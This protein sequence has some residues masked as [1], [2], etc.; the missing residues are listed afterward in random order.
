MIIQSK[1]TRTDPQ[2][3]FD[4]LMTRLHERHYRMTP[5]RVA[6]VRLLAA[7]EG[8]PG[9]AAL[10]DKLRAQFPTTSL[11]TVYKTLAL[12]DELGEVLELDF[13]E[14]TR[15]DGN[16]PYPHAHLICIRC[17]KIVDADIELDQALERE[18]AQ[19]SGFH[20]VGHRL[21]FQG[22]CPE[23]QSKELSVLQRQGGKKATQ[24]Q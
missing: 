24:A 2:A 16:R 19:A 23:C 20:I 10:F 6:L 4:Q 5:Q 8:H 13:S 21:D 7:S 22:V 3:R 17:G 14:G 15:Y 18:A 9:A 1:T 11:A 12:L